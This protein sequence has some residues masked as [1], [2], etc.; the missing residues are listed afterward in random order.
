VTTPRHLLRQSVAITTPTQDGAVDEFGDPTDSTSSATFLGY[1]YQRVR[2]EDTSGRVI[3]SEELGL[4][5]VPEARDAI[6]GN[7][8]VTVDGVTYELDGPPWPAFNPRTG[9]V[10]HVEATLRR[11]A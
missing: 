1:L 9:E 2:G 3:Q 6:N 5:L 4:V 7:S 11:T 8:R 10:E